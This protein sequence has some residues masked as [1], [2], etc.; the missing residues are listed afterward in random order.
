MVFPTEGFPTMTWILQKKRSEI[1]L[2]N[3]NHNKF[4]T[5]FEMIHSTAKLFIIRLCYRLVRITLL[6]SHVCVDKRAPAN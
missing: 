3:G 4:P 2:E 5:S 1:I 6:D